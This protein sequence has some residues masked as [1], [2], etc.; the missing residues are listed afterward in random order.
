[1]DDFNTSCQ[2]GLCPKSQVY[3]HPLIPFILKLFMTSENPVAVHLNHTHIK[4]IRYYP[5]NLW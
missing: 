3:E 4:D 2:Y 1:M 5:T